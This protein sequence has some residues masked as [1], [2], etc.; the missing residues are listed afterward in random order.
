MLRLPT[1]NTRKTPVKRVRLSAKEKLAKEK[2]HERYVQRTYD[3]A[4]GEYAE[5]LAEQGGACA[6]CGKK[7][8]RRRLAVDHDHTSNQVRGLLCL[9]CNTAI[10][11]FEFDGP[12]AQRAAEYLASIARDIELRAPLVEASQP[13]DPRMR[14]S[15]LPRGDLPW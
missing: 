6:I 12:T 7:P 13:T 5:R 4:P 9:F 11:V 14:V 10:G 8:R 15:T 3:L 2:T 1:L